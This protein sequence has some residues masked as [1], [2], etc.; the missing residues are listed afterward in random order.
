[1]GNSPSGFLQTICT[2]YTWIISLLQAPCNDFWW[3]KQVKMV[4][5]QSWTSICMY[6]PKNHSPDIN[7]FRR[8][9][10]TSDEDHPSYTSGFITDVEWISFRTLMTRS[11]LEQISKIFRRSSVSSISPVMTSPA[12]I[13]MN[14]L[15]HNLRCDNHSWLFLQASY[16]H[17]RRNHQKYYWR[18]WYVWV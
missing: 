10:K 18:H 2:G 15:F 11:Y 9:W 6:S 13:E 4:S 7:I 16:T 5:F 17:P 14:K 3:K 12:N 1:M 8:S